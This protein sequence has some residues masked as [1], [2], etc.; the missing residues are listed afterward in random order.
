MSTPPQTI[1]ESARLNTG[2]CGTW[3]QSTTQ[4]RNGP[5]ERKIR[6]VRLPMAP[7]SSRPRATAQARLW[8]R[9][10]ER[11]MK[12]ITP[13]AIA[14]NRMVSDGPPMLNAAPGLRDSVSIS[15]LPRSWTG[16]P[17][18]QRRHHDR[19]RDD[20]QGEHGHGHAEQHGHPARRRRARRAGLVWAV[21][22][23]LRGAGQ[24]RSSRCLQV[25]HRTAR[26][27][28]CSRALPIGSPHDSQVP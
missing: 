1:A 19:L 3:I 10:A 18:G 27:K 17:V 4:P 8:I 23:A 14:V 12:M 2:Q 24:R 22:P 20:V 26:G 21:G 5:G 7:P 9:R 11:T 28:A 25:T 13:T 6:S 15:R 16:G